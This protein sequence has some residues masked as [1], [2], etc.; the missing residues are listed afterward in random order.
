MLCHGNRVVAQHSG[1]LPRRDW[2]RSCTADRAA[3]GAAH[4]VSQRLPEGN[5]GRHGSPHCSHTCLGSAS[6]GRSARPPEALCCHPPCV[7]DRKHNPRR[8]PRRTPVASIMTD[9][10]TVHNGLSQ[11]PPPDASPRLPFCLPCFHHAT[12]NRPCRFIPS[13]PLAPSP[14]ASLS[15]SP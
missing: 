15:V 1:R 4:R 2:V 12:F 13:W 11:W 14:F 3:H 6:T 5:A 9:R 10:R 8:T 7:F